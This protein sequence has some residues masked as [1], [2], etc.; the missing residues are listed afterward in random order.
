MP[1]DH[2]A[3]NLANIDGL[4]SYARVLT[5]NHAEAEDLV[6]ETYLRAPVL[7]SLRTGSNRKALLFT[8]LRNVWLNP[9]RKQRNSLRFVGIDYCYGVADST[10]ELS[11]DAQDNY[12]NDLEARRVRGAIHKLPLEFREIIVLREYE[13]LS[14]REIAG[15]LDCPVRTVMSRLAKARTQLRILLSESLEQSLLS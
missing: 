7:G 2:D 9:L 10:T 11:E 5:C 12:V 1:C 15:V 14:H 3:N 4:Y 8:I 13:E 6:Q